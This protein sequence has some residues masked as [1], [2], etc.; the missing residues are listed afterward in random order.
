MRAAAAVKFF[1]ILPAM[2]D[3][4]TSGRETL[5]GRPIEEGFAAWAPI[6]SRVAEFSRR[7]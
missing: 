2:L 4:A 7:V 3:A 6:V 1:W 5:N